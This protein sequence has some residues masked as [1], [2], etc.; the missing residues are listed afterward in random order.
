MK[1]FLTWFSLGVLLVSGI[2]ACVAMAAMPR[3]YDGRN[4]TVSVYELKED[5]SSY[6]DSTADGAAAAIIQQNLEKTH[7][8][9]NVT[10]IVFD[11]RGYDTMGEAFILITAVAGSMVILFSRKNEKKEEDENER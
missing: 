1:K 7:A 5:P 10:S 3:S 11:F 2:Y 6:D 8:V 9:N 4:A